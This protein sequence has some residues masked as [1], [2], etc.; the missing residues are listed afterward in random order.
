M[1]AA[2]VAAAEARI[3]CNG[4]G[5]GGRPAGDPTEAGWMKSSR[6]MAFGSAGGGASA[7]WS[8]ERRSCCA[9]PL[10]AL[11]SCG[12]GGGAAI[13]AGLICSRSAWLRTGGWSAT[14]TATSRAAERGGC[15]GG[16]VKCTLRH[17]Y[18]RLRSRS[19]R[20][21]LMAIMRHVKFS[22]RSALGSCVLVLL[23]SFQI[24]VPSGSLRCSS[25]GDAMWAL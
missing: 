25:S 21:M 3:S 11:L 15:G 20:R 24:W 12:R 18:P 13:G 14:A 1:A 9:M 10:G 4:S 23:Y 22:M 2:W 16:A 5:D 17:P 19:A 8:T 7:W 6:F